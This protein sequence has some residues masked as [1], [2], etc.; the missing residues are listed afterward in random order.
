MK[1]SLSI[2]AALV[3]LVATGCSKKDAASSAGTASSAEVK[4]ADDDGCGGTTCGK[5]LSIGGCW[6]NASTST[7]RFGLPKGVDPD[8]AKPWVNDPGACK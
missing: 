6:W 3:V 7:C 8:K 2:V 5:C 1:K 4:T